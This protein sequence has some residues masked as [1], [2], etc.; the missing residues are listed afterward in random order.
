MPHQTKC[1]E[2]KPYADTSCKRGRSTLHRKQVAKVV[3]EFAGNSKWSI[4]AAKNHVC[5]QEPALWHLVK[6]VGLT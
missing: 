2:R 5:S 1:I 6:K 4:V 3:E